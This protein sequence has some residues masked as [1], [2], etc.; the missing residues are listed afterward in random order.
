MSPTSHLS[1]FV[2]P[3]DKQLAVA[4]LTRVPVV[5]PAVAVLLLLSTG[6]VIVADVL[7]LTARLGLGWACVINIVLMYWQFTVVHDAIHR[8]AAKNQTLN[9]WFGRIGIATFA[10]HAS[11]GLFRWAHVQH[12]RFTNGPRDPDMWLHGS[13]WSMPLRWMFL[14][15]GYLFF[16][17][18]QSDRTARRHLR[19]TLILTALTLAVCATLVATGWGLALLML[20]VIPSRITFATVG[21]TFF[22]L[23]HV[24]DDVPAEQDVTL[25]TS[26][27]LGREWLLTP[28]MQW[29]NYHLIHHLFPTMPAYRH[30]QVWSLLEP[31]LRRRNLQ[32]QHGFA[33]RPDVHA[34]I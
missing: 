21:F 9:D 11:L 32:I 13:W 12:H 3:V 8:S 25:A 2:V 1:K 7:A 15:I 19:V 34:G 14:D 24:K 33:L 28:L 4:R 17:S 6:G 29:H 27:R 20:W 26:M 10:P 18:R 22:Y 23:P 30:S 16:V 31:E 5:S